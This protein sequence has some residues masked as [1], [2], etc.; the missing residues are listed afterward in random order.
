LKTSLQPLSM[1]LLAAV[2]STKSP[3][4]QEAAPATLTEIYSAHFDFVWRNARRLGVSEDSADDVAQDVFMVVQRRLASFDGRASIR[5]WL[6]GILVRVTSDHRRTFR[7]K[8]VRNVPLD[9]DA[10]TGELSSTAS[11]PSAIGDAEPME[12]TL[13]L[14]QL[15]AELN[16]E[17]RTLLILSELEQWTLRELAELFG[18]PASTIYSRLI[19]AKRAAEQV[20]TRLQ[21]D[22]KARP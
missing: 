20:Y 17:Q 12:R 19:A 7:R 8:G 13:L 5:A 11:G 22:K 16:E 15:L 9:H 2:D 6:F 18:S 21:C 3:A 14:Q 4:S 10:C 1:P